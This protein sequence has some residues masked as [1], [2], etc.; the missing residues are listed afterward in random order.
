MDIAE[1]NRIPFFCCFGRG[2]GLSSGACTDLIPI[3]SI[4]EARMA[5]NTN[6]PSETLITN[7]HKYIRN[8]YIMLET[9]DLERA[10]LIRDKKEK[11]EMKN[12]VKNQ[13]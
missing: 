8:T 1:E 2:E 13:R 7:I 6:I 10:K 11:R 4:A 12:L 3:I 9:Q 5:R